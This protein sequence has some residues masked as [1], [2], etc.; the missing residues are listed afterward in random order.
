MSG[1]IKKRFKLYGICKL[2]K[3]NG[4]WVI[5]IIYSDTISKSS[6]VVNK[7]FNSTRIPYIP[8]YKCKHGITTTFR[9]ISDNLEK[10]NK[11]YT[12]RVMDVTNVKL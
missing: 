4:N 9:I 2:K 7:M 5:N 1:K 8:N 3:D 11:D 6:D 10:L 12:Y